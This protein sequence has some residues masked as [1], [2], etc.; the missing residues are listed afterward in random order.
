MAD[1]VAVFN[2]GRIVQVGDAGGNLRAAAHAV[3]RRFRRRLQRHRAGDCARRGPGIDAAGEPA[4]RKRSRS[5]PTARRARRRARRSRAASAQVLYHGA[6]KRVEL[7]DR[8]RARCSLAVP[9]AAA[10]R[11]QQGDARARRLLPRRPASH[12]AR[13]DRRRARVAPPRDGAAAPH[14]RRARRAPRLLL[15]LLLAPPLLWLGIIYLGS[16]FALLAQSFFSIDEFSGAIVYEP[17]LKTYAELLAPANL[18]IIVRTLAIAAVVTLLA[19][20]RRLPDRLLRRALRARPHEGALLRRGDDAAVVELS[21]QGLCLEA[22]A[23]QGR[24]RRLGSMHAVGLA[25]V[26]DA[27]ARAAARRRPVAL[28]Q[29]H[30]H[31]AG[32]PLPLD[33]R[34]WSCRCRR[35]S[36]ACRRR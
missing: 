15:L 3:R 17:T 22:A 6:V 34:S 23:R 36:S 11:S 28:G 21:R 27:L 1:R 5:S 13:H 29:L 16:L 10:R 32:V 18:D 20:D 26:L 8:R 31:G 30:R 19:V 35:R 9:A 25:P 2:H 12:G 24:R 33:C 4:A 14:L 7:V